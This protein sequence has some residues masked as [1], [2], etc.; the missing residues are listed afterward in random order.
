MSLQVG[1]C[2]VRGRVAIDGVERRSLR[3]VSRRKIAAKLPVGFLGDILRTL[4]KFVTS[5]GGITNSRIGGWM[6]CG[7]REA[8]QELHVRIV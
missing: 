4:Q 2:L 6:R 1:A 7:K 8:Q 5:T 3:R